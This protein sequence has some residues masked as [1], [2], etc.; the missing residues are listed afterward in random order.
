LKGEKEKQYVNQVFQQPKINVRVSFK[1]YLN[2][3]KLL[4]RK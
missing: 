3:M 4:R 1:S 2:I